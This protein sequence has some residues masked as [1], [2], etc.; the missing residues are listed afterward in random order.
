MLLRD[1]NRFS[2]A[3]ASKG[4]EMVVPVAEQNQR[5]AMLTEVIFR[6]LNATQ[7]MFPKRSWRNRCFHIF[8]EERNLFIKNGKITRFG[9]DGIR[10]INHPDVII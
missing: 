1:E 4:A 3:F 10:Q 6:K 5:Q 2:L 7:Q 8:A 9:N